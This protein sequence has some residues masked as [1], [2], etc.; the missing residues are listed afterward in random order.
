MG[1]FDTVRIGAD[2][3]AEWKLGCS[4]CG[5]PVAADA[6]WQTKSLDPGLD[7]YFLRHGEGGICLFFLDPPHDRQFWR[8]W[9]REEIEGSRTAG[10]PMAGWFE[11][12][13]GEGTFLPEAYEPEHRRQAV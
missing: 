7:E 1:L 4:R 12:R 6:E 8:A 10:H 3:A 11:K 2:V 13:E 9:T 5:H